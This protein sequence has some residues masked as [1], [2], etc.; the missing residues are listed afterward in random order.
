MFRAWSSFPRPFLTLLH[1]IH[2]WVQVQQQLETSYLAVSTASVDTLWQTI[3]GAM[4]FECEPLKDK[5]SHPTFSQRDPEGF[6][7][8]GNILAGRS[9]LTHGLQSQRLASS[10][11]PRAHSLFSSSTSAEE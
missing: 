6:Q 8:D 3:A 1:L 7:Q 5:P 4:Q 11:P 2:R 10:R 9:R